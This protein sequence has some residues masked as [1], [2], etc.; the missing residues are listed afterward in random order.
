MIKRKN[1][2]YLLL[3]FVVLLLFTFYFLLKFNIYI[4]CYFHKI[5]NLYC[6]SCGIT[7][8]VIAFFRGDFYQAFRYNVLVYVFIFLIFLFIV[9]SIYSFY[10]N[11]GN[12]FFKVM[13]KKIFKYLITII[14]L[15]GILRNIFLFLAPVEV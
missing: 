3:F 1:Y 8:A 15:F 13:N 6:P 7:R 9:C 4:P 2:H 11:I 12:I 14:V 5:T 10:R